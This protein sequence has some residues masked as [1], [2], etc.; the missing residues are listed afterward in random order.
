MLAP[1]GYLDLQTMD[2]QFFGD[3][4]RIDHSP[5]SQEYHYE[6]SQHDS[7]ILNAELPL[8]ENNFLDTTKYKA[9]QHISLS[10]LSADRRTSNTSNTGKGTPTPGSQIKYEDHRPRN[11]DDATKHKLWVDLDA[12][13]NGPDYG[14]GRTAPWFKFPTVTQHRPEVNYIQLMRKLWSRSWQSSGEADLMDGHI[15]AVHCMAGASP[16]P[17]NVLQGEFVFL[18]DFLAHLFPMMVRAATESDLVRMQEMVNVGND[19]LR[20]MQILVDVE[21][22]ARTKI[23]NTL[24]K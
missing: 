16:Y 18:A 4:T 22:N 15:S 9:A 3:A 5:F 1:G 14:D 20:S 17:P 8:E 23:N 12:S 24:L 21:A 2:T 11:G 10:P 19:F 13:I 7:D 6:E